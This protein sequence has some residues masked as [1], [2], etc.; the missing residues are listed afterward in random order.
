[1]VCSQ[2]DIGSFYYE[3]HNARPSRVK[4]S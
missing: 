1:M 3:R 2:P 4:M